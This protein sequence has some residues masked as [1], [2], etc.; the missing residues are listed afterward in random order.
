MCVAGRGVSCSPQLLCDR[1]LTS[2]SFDADLPFA[3]N[4]EDLDVFGPIHHTEANSPTRMGCFVAAI[5]LNQIL[6][7]ALRTIVRLPSLL[8][9]GIG[10]WYHYSIQRE[11]RELSSATLEK[12]G[13]NR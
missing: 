8:F 6:A 11:N 4:D 13:K 3:C 5:K 7:F 10:N 1:E 12:I 2:N 9:L